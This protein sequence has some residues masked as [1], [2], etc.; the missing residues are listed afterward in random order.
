MHILEADDVIKVNFLFRISG[1][2]KNQLY[3]RKVIEEMVKNKEVD[4][5]KPLCLRQQKLKSNWRLQI[6]S[7][8]KYLSLE[9]EL[10]L[11]EQIIMKAHFFI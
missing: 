9:N 11:F 7:L 2:A 1:G 4:I 10:S 5:N 6:C 3:L 8:E